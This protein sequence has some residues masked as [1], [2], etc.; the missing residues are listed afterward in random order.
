[1]SFACF[2]L[3]WHS[4]ETMST[5]DSS[6]EWQTF[7][8][9]GVSV[10]ITKQDKDPVGYTYCFTTQL[11]DLSMLARQW[12]TFSSGLLLTTITEY[13]DEHVLTSLSVFSLLHLCFQVPAI[14]C[15]WVSRFQLCLL[16]F[17]FAFFHSVFSFVE[18]GFS[19]HF[20]KISLSRILHASILCAS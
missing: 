13:K 1:M 6:R 5:N 7:H 14:S 8:W 17:I 10:L 20:P 4:L 11:N 19:M 15:S 3:R 9:K 16:H 12:Q 18:G 2:T